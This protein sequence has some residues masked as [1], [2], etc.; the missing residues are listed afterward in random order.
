MSTPVGFVENIIG[1]EDVGPLF[2]IDAYEK[3]VD[4]LKKVSING[5]YDRVMEY[6][7][8]V[9]MGPFVRLFGRIMK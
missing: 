5:N 3:I 6:F 9:G 4:L 8:P 1:V 7:I 2:Q